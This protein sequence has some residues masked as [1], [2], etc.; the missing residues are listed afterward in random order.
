MSIFVNSQCLCSVKNSFWNSQKRGAN[1]F[2]YSIDEETIIAAKKFG[3]SFI[4]LAP[5]KFVSKSRDFLIGDADNYQ[6]LVAEDMENLRSILDM[7][8]KHEVPVV[9][10]FLSLPGSRFKQKNN[11]IDD[12]RLWQNDNF[13]NQASQFWQDVA[14]AFKDHPA[15]VGYDILNEP[16]PERCF[17]V[18]QSNI[19]KNSTQKVQE[20]LYNFNSKIVKAIR[21]VDKKTPIIIESSGYAY[22]EALEKMIPVEDNNALYS[23]HM[24]AP[25]NYTFCRSDVDFSYPGE[26]ADLDTGE[27]V[28]WC[29]GTIDQYLKSVVRWQEKYKISSSRIL[30]GEFGVFRYLNGAANY[31]EDLISI[32]NTNG[33]HWAVYSFREDNWDKMNY[34]LKNTV[35][36]CDY[37]YAQE[38]KRISDLYDS[39]NPVFMVFRRAWKENMLSATLTQCGDPKIRASEF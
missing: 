23:F 14:K 32:F 35:G 6:G 1:I 30:V 26:I 31:L 27:G 21:E 25:E 29:A 13:L 2:N 17:G 9:L 38:Q 7:F 22:P 37:W 5:D 10:V 12:L 8:Y 33:W 39:E 4:R 34:E 3:I 24:Y 16:H 11:S 20:I 19:A 18:S 15:I 36:T 28:Y